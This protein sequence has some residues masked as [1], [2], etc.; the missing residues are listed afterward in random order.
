VPGIQEFKNQVG[1]KIS[2]ETVVTVVTV[3]TGHISLVITVPAVT[4]PAPAHAL[5]A[6][7]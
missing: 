3:V 5:C 2:S 4:L 6:G 7:R 1:I